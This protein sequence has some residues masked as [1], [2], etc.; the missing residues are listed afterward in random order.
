MPIQVMFM[1]LRK[2]HRLIVLL[3]ILAAL[4]VAAW[5]LLLEELMFNLQDWV[6]ENPAWSFPALIALLVV[7]ILLMLPASVMMM[8]S[9]F[10]FGLGK[11]FL[12]V[13]L[14]VVLA[15]TGAFW[16]ARKLAR[17]MVERR[18]ATRPFFTA[19]DR[20]IRRKGFYVVLLTRL[21][22][23]LP[24]PAL[25]YSHG[26]TDVRLRDY[27]AGTMIG[28]VPPIFLFVYLGTLASGVA[29]IVNGRVKLEGGQLT[30]VV[31]GS[32]LVLLATVVIVMAAR[33][34][35]QGEIARASNDASGDASGDAVDHAP[36]NKI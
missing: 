1:G 34:A 11:G 27:V 10:L 28:M 20:A 24:F 26:L 32:V 29:D 33:K 3:L 36:K 23:L 14:A 6:D 25:N 15:S 2:S 7:G 21:I 19:I 9:G 17:P 4:L 16:I 13:W 5:L 18:L 35:L 22:L 8:V 12:A 30:A 31:L